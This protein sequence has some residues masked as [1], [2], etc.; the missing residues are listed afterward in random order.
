MAMTLDGSNGVTFNDASLQGAAASPYV[1]KNRI[2]N[3][4][5]VVAQR[6]TSATVS[7]GSAVGFGADRFQTDSY[8]WS[9]GSNITVSN[10]TTVVPSGFTNSY[11]WA[12]GATGLTFAS[13]GFQ[14]ITQKIEGYNIADAYSGNVTISFWVRSSTAGTYT[15]WIANNYGS[16]EIY[17]TK[18]YTINS[19]NT[20][21][22][23]SITVDLSGGI[24]AGGTWN[25]TNG[26]GLSLNWAL[27]G[28]AN[29]TGNTGLNTWVNTNT[30]P[31]YHWNTSSSVQLATIANSTFYI[32]GVQLEIGSTATPFE[33]RMYG[34]ELALCQRYYT[35]FNQ[36]P[37]GATRVAGASPAAQGYMTATLPVQMRSA[38]TISLGTSGTSVASGYSYALSN[39]SSDHTLSTGN[40]LE[41]QAQN[42]TVD[43]L[44]FIMKSTAISWTVDR[45][46]IM[47]SGKVFASAEL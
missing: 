33:R 13:G 45:P 4:D 22:Q 1:L 11:K 3:G 20:W 24:A 34:Q 15:L 25:K 44:N 39:G 2:I 47:T 28:N 37:G 5:M 8:T 18:Q 29:R 43:V 17:T 42:S 31:T 21:E 16:S 32:T 9:A 36:I 7:N 38:P 26:E 10:E 40:N 41:I 30:T 19:A 35:L 23:K 6:G 12:N 27:G 14:S 46:L